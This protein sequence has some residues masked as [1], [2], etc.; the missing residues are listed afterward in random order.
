MFRRDFDERSTGA[1]TNIIQQA[2]TLSAADKA[3]VKTALV[4]KIGTL[5]GKRDD[6]E[7]EARAPLSS[8]S[9]GGSLLSSAAGGAAS[10]VSM[11]SLSSV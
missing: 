2:Q 9:L 8:T 11:L 1:L 5:Q 7:L 10:A 4:N 6:S 3:T